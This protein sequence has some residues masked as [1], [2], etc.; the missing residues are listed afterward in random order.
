[1]KAMIQLLFILLI[2]LAG[3]GSTGTVVM[4][5]TDLP[6]EDVT[7]AEVTLS[8]VRVHSTGVGNE[9]EAGW[10]TVNEGPVTFDLVQLRNNV[11][12]LLGQTELTPGKYTQI[13]LS[14]DGASAT[15]AGE[16]VELTIPSNEIK[17][18]HPF[19]IVAGETVTLVLDWDVAEA[20]H[21]AGNTY[22]MRPTI[23]IMQE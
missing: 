5:I 8:Q 22:I 20:I 21:Q 6:A 9:T 17:L 16:E 14:V 4:K 11:T 10:S 15:I 18:V 3:C 12:A 1:M 2:S 7:K 13:R 23:K 19:D